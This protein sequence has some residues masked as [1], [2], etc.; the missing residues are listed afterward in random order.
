MD[1]VSW[2]SDSDFSYSDSS[3]AQSQFS[4]CDSQTAQTLSDVGV[5]KYIQKLVDYIGVLSE[6]N[7]ELENRIIKLENQ[8]SSRPEQQTKAKPLN[9]TKTNSTKVLKSKEKTISNHST[10]KKSSPARK[11][12]HISLNIPSDLNAR[13]SETEQ[14][15]FDSCNLPESCFIS[16][17]I[18]IRDV[19]NHHNPFLPDQKVFKLTINVPQ[20]FRL[21]DFINNAAHILYPPG[22]IVS[23]FNFPIRR[24]TPSTIS[25]RF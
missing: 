7:K 8:N 20:Q 5:F 4:G 17:I 6:K 3:T 14:Q 1:S 10:V 15:I 12:L 21:V 18:H 24:S 16:K 11:N 9:F 25:S 19:N 2:H 22:S 23:K 13:P